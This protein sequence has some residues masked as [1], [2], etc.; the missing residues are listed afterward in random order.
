VS[1]PA[2]CPGTCVECCARFHGHRYVARAEAVQ[3]F[4]A[5]LHHWLNKEKTR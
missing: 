2:R 1:F 4:V 5:E 3:E